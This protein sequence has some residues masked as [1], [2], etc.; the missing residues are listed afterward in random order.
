LST[1]R[2][3]RAGGHILAHV[4]KNAAT[5]SEADAGRRRRFV[6]SAFG[7]AVPARRRQSVQALMNA[8]RP[9]IILIDAR[10]DRGVFKKIDY[11]RH[12]R[13]V[14]KDQPWRPQ[15][16][17][18]SWDRDELRRRAQEWRDSVRPRA[19]AL[20]AAGQAMLRAA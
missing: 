17:I 7:R 15:R 4:G 3:D 9:V 10:G 13:A 14:R 16:A 11:R 5:K 2:A 12:H 19:E 8:P 6:A 18:P 1:P 20:K